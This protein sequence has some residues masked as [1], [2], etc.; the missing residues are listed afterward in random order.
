LLSTIASL[1]LVSA[2]G[3]LEPMYFPRLIG[4]DGER[5]LRRY[6]SSLRWLVTVSAAGSVAM[7]VVY[8]AF[9]RRDIVGS[10][11]AV[12]VAVIGGTSALALSQIPHFTLYRLGYDRQILWCNVAAGVSGL[13]AASI[14]TATEGMV[15]T[16]I[17]LA[18]GS[19]VLFATKLCASRR[20]LAREPVM[21]TV[22]SSVAGTGSTP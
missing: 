8:N 21:A 5:E 2:K 11:W 7:A 12:L 15:G 9:G 17:G 22:A 4:A 18:I 14:L 3:V 6:A 20:D 10:D 1:G 16:G 13:V 19:V